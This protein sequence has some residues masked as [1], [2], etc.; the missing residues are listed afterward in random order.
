ML[1]IPLLNY[2]S[3]LTQGG[4]GEMEKVLNEQVPYR[5]VICFPISNRAYSRGS[6]TK[7][8]GPDPTHGVISCAPHQ[9]KGIPLGLDWVGF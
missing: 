4:A 5:L 9:S 1:V 7:A 3:D 2:R 8:H 6:Q